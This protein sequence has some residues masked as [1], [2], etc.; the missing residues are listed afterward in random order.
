LLFHLVYVVALACAAALDPAGV[1]G[2]TTNIWLAWI[3]AVPAAAILTC[4]EW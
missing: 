3:L 2:A 4:T 1:L